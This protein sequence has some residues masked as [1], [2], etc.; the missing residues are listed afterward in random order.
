VTRKRTSRESSL[1]RRVPE[2]M[3]LSAR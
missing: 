1:R 2:E 3:V